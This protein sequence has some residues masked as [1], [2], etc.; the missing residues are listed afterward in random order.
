M[1]IPLGIKQISLDEILDDAVNKEEIIESFVTKELLPLIPQEA[2]II[3]FD[4]FDGVGKTSI[5]ECVSRC[6]EI[7]H[8]NLD[9]FLK[10]DQ[11]EF[12]NAIKFDEL[13]NA[14]ASAC[15]DRGRIIVDGCM[16]TKV[17]KKINYESS[18]SIYLMHTTR[19]H[20][21]DELDSCRK[22][23][24]L[25]GDK[26]AEEL[27]SEREDVAQRAAQS[28]SPFFGGG[29]GEIPALERELIHYHRELR[30]HDSADLIIKIVHWI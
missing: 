27:I 8:F 28:S 17:L 20:L 30:P 14:M 13:S 9:K 6:L 3:T 15:N 25:Y 16:L 18:F 10:E 23:E 22:Y 11:N 19:M 2:Q 29:S 1:D 7:P 5:A 24:I 26:S 4:G 21:E 12:F